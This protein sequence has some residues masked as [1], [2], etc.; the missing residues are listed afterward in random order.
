MNA[1]KRCNGKSNTTREGV[2]TATTLHPS[3]STSSLS[4]LHPRD[5]TAQD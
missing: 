3:S 4:L 2:A 5:Q 1:H